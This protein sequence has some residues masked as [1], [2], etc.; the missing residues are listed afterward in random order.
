M[1]TLNAYFYEIQQ[2]GHKISRDYGLYKRWAEAEVTTA[3]STFEIPI[4]PPGV[5]FKIDLYNIAV[6]T[7]TNVEFQVYGTGAWENTVSDYRDAFVRID[8]A[9]G[10]VFAS[11]NGTTRN[12]LEIFTDLGNSS[13]AKGCGTVYFMRNETQNDTQVYWL[14]TSFKTDGTFRYSDGLGIMPLI[15]RG[16]KA[17]LIVDTGTIDEGYA[18]V[19][20]ANPYGVTGWELPEDSI[21]PSNIPNYM[22]DPPV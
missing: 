6:T 9:A 3:A 22:G 21:H 19:W 10:S 4:P 16:G 2:T 15:M 12:G 8:D 5:W 1:G 14:T 13:F 20:V 18:V 11:D 7:Q 17:R